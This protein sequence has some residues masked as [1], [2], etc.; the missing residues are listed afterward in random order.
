MP[1]SLYK[2]RQFCKKHKDALCANVLLS[3]RPN[4]FNDPYDTSVYVNMNHILVE[5]VSLEDA[6]QNINVSSEDPVSER[7]RRL[8]DPI[9]LEDWYRRISEEIISSDPDNMSVTRDIFETADNI[10]EQRTETILSHFAEHLRSEFSVVSLSQ[11]PSSILMW[12][13]YSDA[14]KGFCIEYDFSSMSAADLRRRLCFPVYYRR[15]LTKATRYMARGD[16]KDFNNSFGQYLCLLKSDEWAYER[17]WRIVMQTGSS[18]ETL[19][20]LMPA[21]ASII[22]GLCVEE[23]NV[24]WMVE[25]CKRNE[26]PLMKVRQQRDAFRLE[27]VA[28]GD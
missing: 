26:I 12:S 4:K 11:V 2:Y 24:R 7:S 14:H 10:L 15:K 22:L 28:Y 13:H 18:H 21:P 27:V 20:I 23:H 19:Q 1:N 3:C 5:N 8:Q 9:R 17:E 16:R 6:I 25:H